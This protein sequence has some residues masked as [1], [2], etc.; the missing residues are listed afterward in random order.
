M[1][2]T[3]MEHALK[4]AQ[5]SQAVSSPVLQLSEYN[6]TGTNCITADTSYNGRHSLC[7]EKSFFMFLK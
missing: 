7:T 5:H 3:E 1:N 6:V 4:M 2:N